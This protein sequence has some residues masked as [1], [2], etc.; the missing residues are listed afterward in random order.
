[1]IVSAVG[2]RAVRIVTNLDV[3]KDQA[4]DAASVLAKLLAA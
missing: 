3:S 4:E 1:V 2:P